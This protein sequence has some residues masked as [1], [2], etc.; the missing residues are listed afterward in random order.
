MQFI[1]RMKRSKHS[2]KTAEYIF[3][4]YQ[5]IAALTTIIGSLSIAKIDEITFAERES[6]VKVAL[7]ASV[8][9]IDKSSGFR[10]EF[11]PHSFWK[12]KKKPQQKCACSFSWAVSVLAKGGGHM[13]KT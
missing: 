4:Q 13:H 3:C 6:L 9:E 12:A 5:E 11:L 8:A 2:I 10:Y 7:L 1:S